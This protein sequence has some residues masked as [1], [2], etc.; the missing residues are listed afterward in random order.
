MKE[1]ATVE[2]EAEAVAPITSATEAAAQPVRP[3]PCPCVARCF[4]L[5]RCFVPPRRGYRPALRFA[6]SARLPPL[7]SA[8]SLCSVAAC[9]QLAPPPPSPPPAYPQAPAAAAATATALAAPARGG[10]GFL[11]SLV[12]AAVM[13]LAVATMALAS[14]ALPRTGGTSRKAAGSAAAPA[15]APAQPAPKGFFGSK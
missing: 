7:P 15:G 12:G 2:E 11:R 10:R 13:A 14:S 3:P 4:V 9:P 5:P 8:L 1:P 6:A